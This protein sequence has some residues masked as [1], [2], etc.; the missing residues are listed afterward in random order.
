MDFE[1]L[2]IT[3]NELSIIKCSLL[4]RIEQLNDKIEENEFRIE[5]AEYESVVRGYHFSNKLMM[6]E[7]SKISKI[8]EKFEVFYE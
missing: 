5:D 8:I 1:D 4:S 2:A 3:L 6:E 7:I